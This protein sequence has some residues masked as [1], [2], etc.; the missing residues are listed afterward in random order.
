VLGIGIFSNLKLHAKT[1]NQKLNQRLVLYLEL[2]AFVQDFFDEDLELNSR[3]VLTLDEGF[4][5]PVE[6]I[7]ASV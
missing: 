1:I 3:A 7:R 4:N 2:N 5:H 6:F